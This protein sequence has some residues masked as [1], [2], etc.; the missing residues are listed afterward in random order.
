L[1]STLSVNKTLIQHLHE[2]Y[3]T[4]LQTFN[5]ASQE[6]VK[7]GDDNWYKHAGVSMR[8]LV[9]NYG[10]P[11]DICVQMLVEHMVDLLHY[12]EKRELLSLLYVSDKQGDKQGDKQSEKQSN[13]ELMTM[14]KTY[15]DSQW[16]QIKKMRM[17]VIYK[18]PTQ[19]HIV[20]L[21]ENKSVVD[22]EPEDIRDYNLA[23]K[24]KEKEAEPL[25]SIVGFIGFENNN[26][27]LVF[28]LKQTDQKRNTGARCDE[29]VK[30]KKVQMLNEIFEAKD[31]FV[32]RIIS[33][34]ER[35]RGLV[36][37]KS[38]V[39]AELC[40]FMEFIL[41][42]YQLIKKDGKVWFI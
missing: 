33:D 3:A 21:D 6:K 9:A 38:L 30:S 35:A 22:A 36:S 13:D 4:A 20:L 12:E 1:Q 8:K 27:Y 2:N 11:R 32:E 26:Q 42:Y 37:T 15:V 28:K 16:V 18:T 41:R 34:E 5:D 10:V 29:A 39:Q 23:E 7:R 14:I 40:S 31:K 24:E 25:H 17:M 19:K